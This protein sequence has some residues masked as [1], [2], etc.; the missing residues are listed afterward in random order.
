MIE[1]IIGLS[2]PNITGAC[3]SAPIDPSRS[4]PR[5]QQTSAHRQTCRARATLRNSL[6]R[7]TKPPP[8]TSRHHEQRETR[9]R[10]LVAGSAGRCRH[11]GGRGSRSVTRTAASPYPPGNHPQ[12]NFAQYQGPVSC[13]STK[14]STRHGDSASP[15]V[16]ARSSRT[17][18]I[19]NTTGEDATS[20]ASS[21]QHPGRHTPRA[22]T[23]LSAVRE[24]R[25]ASMMKRIL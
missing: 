17:R 4:Q 8:S 3:W 1:D 6:G 24:R 9:R 25:G 2:R 18:V 16:K 11:D 21:G 13:S 7:S 22:P 10:R 15:R 23:S 5:V 19:E 20:W 14:T 12:G